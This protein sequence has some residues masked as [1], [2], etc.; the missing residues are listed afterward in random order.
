[1]YVK[2]Q[3]KKFD[4]QSND[5]IVN[6]ESNKAILSFNNDLL[7]WTTKNIQIFCPGFILLIVKSYYFICIT[8]IEI[9]FGSILNTSLLIIFIGSCKIKQKKDL[10]MINSCSL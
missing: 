5:L 3:I 7:P 4:C 9:F 6:L 2:K 8:I 1:L 10:S